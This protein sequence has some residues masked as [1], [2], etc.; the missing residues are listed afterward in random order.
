MTVASHDAGCP[1]NGTPID[2]SDEAKACSDAVNLHV[3]A[4]GFD[5]VKKWVAI[6][7]SDGKSDGTLY[8][9]KRDAVA[10][11]LDEFLC[12]YVCI[13]PSGMNACQAES[14]LQVH[15]KLYEAGFRLADR[16]APHGGRQVIPRLTRE[17]QGALM[18][19]L[20]R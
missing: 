9:T 19:T 14:Y 3:A 17:A 18:A 6:R 5:A 20:R 15:R 10:H 4:I 13:P 7:L 16:D 2:H 12:A 1:A 11:Q 8:D